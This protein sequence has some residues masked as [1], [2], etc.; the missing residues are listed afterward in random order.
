MEFRAMIPMDVKRTSRL[1]NRG[2][3]KNMVLLV[4]LMV[5]VFPAFTQ[6][7]TGIPV[8]R[9]YSS[10]EYGSHVQNWAIVE[11]PGGIMYYGNTNGEILE[12]DGENWRKIK[13]PNRS[14]VRSM[15]VDKEGT[16][17]VGAVDEFGYLKANSKERLEYRS[18]ISLL[19]STVR[20]FGNVWQTFA[21]DHGVYFSTDAGLFRV[22][23][24]EVKSW[25]SCTDNFFVAY[26][27]KK[28][29]FIQELGVGLMKLED[30]NLKPIPGSEL[31]RDN[32][33]YGIL[34][35]K[36]EK[37]LL[38]THDE[39]IYV[40][41]QGEPDEPFYKAKGFKE[42]NWF[43]SR[44]NP[45]RCTVLNDNR[46]A[47]A[48][49]QGGIIIADG[50][51]N[52]ERIIN[53]EE[54]LI[55]DD[56]KYI[57]Q[58]RRQNLHL[59]LDAGIAFAEIS[60]PISKY[61]ERRG[62][63]GSLL[64]I[65]RFEDE[66]YVGSTK[67]IFVLEGN[68]F[69]KIKGLNEFA[70]QFY[71]Y[72]PL[73][74]ETSSAGDSLLLVGSS[75]AFYQLKNK[76]P[77]KI[78]DVRNAF[79]MLQPDENPSLL[80][81]GLS[82]G[83]AVYEYRGG[84][85]KFTDKIKGVDREIR[86]MVRDREGNIWLGTAFKGIIR[87]KDVFIN[88]TFNRQP[89]VT[90]YSMDEG[91]PAM[92]WNFGQ[93]IQ[94][95]LVF[96]TPGGLYHFN[97]RK[98]YFYPDTSFVKQLADGSRGVHCMATDK[99]GNLWTASMYPGKAVP[100]IAIKQPDDTY[101]WSDLSFKR[102]TGGSL[103]FIYPEEN[104]ICWLGGTEG[105]YRYDPTNTKDYEQ[106]YDCLVRKVTIG[107]DSVIYWGNGAKRRAESSVK[108][109][110]A[111][112]NMAFEYAAPLFEGQ[113]AVCYSYYLEGQDEE[114]S[115][116]AK[117][118]HKHY[119]NLPEG[120][121]VFK[122][123]A[124]GVYDR[125]STV[126]GYAFTIAPPWY[127]TL[128]A[129]GF[130]GLFSVLFIGGIVKVYTKRLV[131][132]REQLE[133]TVKERTAELEQSNRELKETIDLVNRQ[134]IK[135]QTQADQLKMQNERLIELDRFKETMTT[136]IV[137][138]LKNSLNAIINVPENLSEEG[139]KLVKQSAG[140]MLNM[141]MNILDI[142]KYENSRMVLNT[143]AHPLY[144][145][146]QK[147]M[148]E[149]AFLNQAKHISIRNHVHT[150]IYIRADKE[151]IIRVLINLLTNAI[152]FTPVGGMIRVD[153]SSSEF[154]GAEVGEGVVS[155]S[156]KDNGE[157][158]PGDQLEKVFDKFTQVEAKNTGKAPSSG[159]GLTFCR[160]AVEAHGGEIVAES[161]LGKGSVFRFTLPADKALNKT[162]AGANPPSTPLI[163]VFDLP[164]KIKVVLRPYVNRLKN[165]MIN[166]TTEIIYI[167]NNIQHTGDEIEAW[168]K[169]LEDCLFTLDEERY[170]R[171]IRLD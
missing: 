96:G 82:N 151:I 108:I 10:G 46:F 56:V 124:I 11:G 153:A 70:W 52:I 141:V 6:K 71:S 13:I 80:F 23:E 169:E 73:P 79:C 145:I 8:I 87:M 155:V 55:G 85:W 159:L 75:S 166:E 14:I 66:L 127:R 47:L 1:M 33:I 104:G 113:D 139:L 167:L 112:N 35:Y 37:M 88:D 32:R 5:V 135:I 144:E 100:G 146:V 149:V 12:Y 44:N 9:N 157:G 123:K 89:V 21:M 31:F 102:I 60:S 98:E 16:I 99:K 36:K 117:E 72:K 29:L 168:K 77:D 64:S 160:M 18:Y 129:Y 115:E 152:K 118:T 125:E 91:L 42:L 158:I 103:Y 68:R 40:Y 30:E 45:Y 54:G 84:E 20:G 122:V 34:P 86:N 83:V 90:S 132:H 93:R 95:K 111:A 121:Y 61:D 137:H 39:G 27:V 50:S 94:D 143:S 161:E 97:E 116:W 131:R 48:T 63:E 43:L 133:Q 24:G 138:D 69:R 59:A 15:D 163:D 126:A 3:S 130:Y 105:L 106:P 62:L 41:D 120:D 19:D 2:H 76:R 78:A 101:T 109:D 74:V 128:W 171:L 142:Y 119:T 170:S 67:G 134:K 28:S 58:D 57:Y 148:G 136:T 156:V 4:F 140:Q 150:E 147:A 107:K 38:I 25:P 154:P 162:K 22:R 53:K 49:R 165:L 92:D 164:E 110:Y 7:E 65:I 81:V 17:Y 51:G 114:W 26:R